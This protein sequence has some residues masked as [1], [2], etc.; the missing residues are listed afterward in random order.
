MPPF[1]LA[2]HITCLTRHNPTLNLFPPT[3]GSCT[4]LEK[5]YFRLTAAPD[6]A[7]VRPQPILRR[8]LDRLVGLLRDGSVN[9]FYACDQFK[10]LRQDCTVQHLRDELV[11]AVYE[12]H[13][14][15]ALEY[16]DLAEFN[17]CQTQLAGLYA[18]SIRGC[19][20]EFMAYKLLYNTAHAAAGAN[21][22]LLHTVRAA[23]ALTAEKGADA[24]GAV[25]NALAARTAAFTSDFPAFFAAYAAA[26]ALGRALLDLIAKK[27]RWVG[28]N[29]LVKAYKTPLPV[30]FLATTFG[31]CPQ[32]ARAAP[33]AGA[34]SGGSG[35][36]GANG[37]PAQPLPGCKLAVYVGK[38]AAAASEEEGMQACVAWLQAHGAVVDTAGA[39]RSSSLRPSVSCPSPGLG[40]GW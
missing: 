32:P 28:L 40:D 14:R 18:D 17:Q 27:L 22:A 9:Y 16:G 24:H 31:F 33:T 19:H 15:A 20:A 7:V 26:P 38:A 39:C 35:Q 4:E 21:K 25:T 2:A 23:L 29:V 12:A 10:G 30:S 37:V 5:S 8:A 6:P 34:G 11:V 36:A 1:R 3:Q 13:A